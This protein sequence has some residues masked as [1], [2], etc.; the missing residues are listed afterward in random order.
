MR[1]RG[2]TLSRGA[3]R[4]PGR[5]GAEPRGVRG[6]LGPAEQDLEL[7]LETRMWEPEQRQRKEQSQGSEGLRGVSPE[8]GEGT[9]ESK[10]GQSPRSSEGMQRVQPER[11]DGW[12]SGKAPAVMWPGAQVRRG[13]CGVTSTGCGLPCFFQGKKFKLQSVG[14]EREEG[15]S[16]PSLWPWTPAQLLG[17]MAQVTPL[18]MQ[19]PSP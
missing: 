14:R 9:L 5:P 12:A 4:A 11:H 16:V 2:G 15:G 10:D 18:L 17:C 1:R 19:G 3:E 8:K 7:Q 13:R 6:R